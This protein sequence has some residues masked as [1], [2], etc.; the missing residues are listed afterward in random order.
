MNIAIEDLHQPKAWRIDFV[1]RAPAGEATP[2]RHPR[3]AWLRKQPADAL[4]LLRDGA[5]QPDAGHE[6][7]ALIYLQSGAATPYE[8]QKQVEAWMAGRPDEH[9][10]SL[11]VQLRSE[12]VLWRRGRAV[13]F[14]AP[15]AIAD[16]LS[17]VG[18]FSFCERELGAL[19]RQIEDAWAKLDSDTALMKQ[20]SSRSLKHQR[21]IDAMARAATAMRVAYVRLQTALETPSDE[22]SP[23]ARR[24]FLELAVQADTLDRLRMVDDSL[25]VFEEFYRHMREQFAEFRSFVSEYRV[26]FLILLVLFGELLLGLNQIMPWASN[27]VHW[28]G[29]LSNYFR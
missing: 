22:L 20:L 4:S 25:E 16:V 29:T 13:C 10:S 28:A 11:E 6:N 24:L 18:M 2:I 9:G 21:H 19:E 17:G 1:D 7:L 14:G 5:A 26:T 8:I 12:R 15:Q 23:A 27:V 3:P